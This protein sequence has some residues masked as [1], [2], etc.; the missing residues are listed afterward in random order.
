[1]DSYFEMMAASPQAQLSARE[2]LSLAPIL[3]QN[4]QVQDAVLLY[5]RV[6]KSKSEP[7][8]K[9]KASIALA[10]LYLL[11]HK[12][13][14][15]REILNWAMQLTTSLPDWQVHIQER[16]NRISGAA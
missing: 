13:A 7:V 6:L 4:E 1:M 16:V 12:Q 10:D 8:V 15:A 11:D 5:H 2:I 3:A 9:L 14:K